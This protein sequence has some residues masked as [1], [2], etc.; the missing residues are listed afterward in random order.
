MIT[1]P[2]PP[3]SAIDI[4]DVLANGCDV[5]VAWY[6]TTASRPRGLAWS[7]RVLA[8][9]GS[10]RTEV[11]THPALAAVTESGG[12]MSLATNRAN[13]AGLVTDETGCRFVPLAANG[14]DAGDTVRE[15]PNR[16][17]G[18]AAESDGFS[19]LTTS[20]QGGTPVDLVRV[21]ARGAVRDRTTLVVPAK[22]AAWARFNFEDGSFVVN[23]FREDPQTGN[24]TDWLQHFAAQGAP[25]APERDVGA[26]T[27][28]VQVASTATGLLAAWSWSSV[29]LAPLTRNG[30][31]AGA[32][33]SVPL[34]GPLYGLSLVSVP[35][36]D[37][38]LFWTEN[39]RANDFN[40]FV[41]AIAPDGTP[42]A[43]ARLFRTTRSTSVV[44]VVVAPEGDRALVVLEGGLAVPLK[45]VR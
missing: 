19:Y 23:T 18:L 9:D 7:T 2:P 15:G 28:P 3:N 44:R 6:T 1:E 10:P 37:A 42:R 25:L 12:E 45:C 29:D 40:L 36:G 39:T 17:L 31:M 27:A 33:Q 34:A 24:Y 13:I 26:N 22:R 5:L 41:Q 32:L 38:M 35:N 8:F 43:P 4:S 21:D 11:Q 16:C 30:V 14:A 20:T